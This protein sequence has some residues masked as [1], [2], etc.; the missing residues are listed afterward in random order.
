MNHANE[1][2]SRG[3][4]NSELYTMYERMNELLDEVK[5]QNETQ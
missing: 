5:I 3:I 4:Q 2:L 1:I